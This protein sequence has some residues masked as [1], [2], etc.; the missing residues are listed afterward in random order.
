MILCRLLCTWSWRGADALVNACRLMKHDDILKVL[1]L[2]MYVVLFGCV[3][4]VLIAV[5]V[6]EFGGF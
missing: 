2:F 3:K 6:L 5:R 4:Y 1:V